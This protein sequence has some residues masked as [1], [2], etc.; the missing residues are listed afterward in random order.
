MAPE[1]VS[2]FGSNHSILKCLD[3]GNEDCL[4]LDH[5]HPGIRRVHTFLKKKDIAVDTIRQIAFS[6][7]LDMFLSSTALD[8]ENRI[9]HAIGMKGSNLRAFA[10][11]CACGLVVLDMLTR[12]NYLRNHC[13]SETASLDEL[14][15]W[16]QEL[17]IEIQRVDRA[18]HWLEV[19]SSSLTQPLKFELW[20]GVMFWHLQHIF[21]LIDD[22]RLMSTYSFPYSFDRL[23][24][25]LLIWQVGWMQTE[26]KIC[27]AVSR[28][29]FC[30]NEPM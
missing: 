15:V 8:D 17:E 19:S 29:M 10:S 20:S 1:W 22:I 12:W 14:K 13:K 27:D 25:G 11:G 30:N 21:F 2:R 18:Q 4:Y 9:E 28:L 16:V 3:M 26:K 7:E 24:S 5:F 6:T 23:D